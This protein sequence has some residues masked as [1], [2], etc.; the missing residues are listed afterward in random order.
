MIDTMIAGANLVPAESALLATNSQT[1]G[2]SWGAIIAGAVTA[3]ALTVALALCGAGFGLGIISPWDHAASTAVK[4]TINAAIWLII[5][6]WVSSAFGGYMAGR[7]RTKWT[8]LH[9]DEMFFR[10]TAHGFL[11]WGLATLIVFG[12]FAA[13]T[14]SLVSDSAKLAGPAAADIAAHNYDLDLLFRQPVSLGGNAANNTGSNAAAAMVTGMTDAETRAEASTILTED[15]G[16]AGASE[17]DKA[18]LVQLVSARLSL[19]PADAQIR[20]DAVLA[21]QAAAFAKA[22]KLADDI[23]KASSAAA[24]YTFLS[25]LVGAFIAS[26]A[27]ALG[28]HFRQQY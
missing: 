4:F 12:I 15:A 1:S 2:T 19:A 14:S 13:A 28:G 18:Y 26:V 11:A 7:L 21:R 20:V 17:A 6:Q 22:Q 3:S 8:D 27:G 23:R 24:L 5:V 9:T 10:D 16:P 25:L